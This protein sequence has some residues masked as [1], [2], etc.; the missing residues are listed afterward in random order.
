MNE[1]RNTWNAGKITTLALFSIAVFAQNTFGYAN[2]GKYCTEDNATCFD[3][4]ANDKFSL[5]MSKNKSGINTDATMSGSYTVN[6]DEFY[7]TIEQWDEKAELEA[8]KKTRTQKATET[9]DVAVK[10]LDLA[11]KANCGQQDPKK[12]AKCQKEVKEGEADIKRMKI[13]RD[14]IKNMTMTVQEKKELMDKFKER[15]GTPGY[16]FKNSIHLESNILTKS[17]LKPDFPKQYYCSNGELKEKGKFTDSRNGK[18]YTYVTIGSQ[19]WMAENLNWHGKDGYL[20]LC[21]GKKPE[22]CEIDG[23]LYDW[24]EAVGIDRKY[25]QTFWKNQEFWKKSMN[26]QGICPEGWYLPGDK[27][28][29]TLINFT[30]GKENAEKKLSVKRGQDES[31]CKYKTEDDRGRVTEHNNCFTDEYGFSGSS[32]WWSTAEYYPT[33]TYGNLANAVSKDYRY[34]YAEKSYARYVRCIKETAEAKAVVETARVAEATALAKRKD[35]EEKFAKTQFKDP[36]GKKYKIAITGGQ[37]WMAENLKYK[38]KGSKCYNNAPDENCGDDVLGRFY[39]WNTARSVC[40]NGWRLPTDA[41]WANAIN[42]ELYPKQFDG[43]DDGNGWIVEGINSARW[44]TSKGDGKSSVALLIDGG[45][46]SFVKIDNKLANSV[47]CVMSES[48]PKEEPTANSESGEKK[49]QKEK[50]KKIN[51]SPFKK[52]K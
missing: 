13:E 21:E 24:A 7:F 9:I 43:Y 6:C 37:I 50:T 35:L 47:R 34:D 8:I 28:W 3:L 18:V 16:I 52:K 2:E 23:R 31:K 48:S 27:E 12:I 22:N 10:V 15:L 44:W 40:P 38:A 20:G 42:D 5:F 17:G 14:N 49:Q 46:G 19:I 39:D 1:Q 36:A 41:E 29:Q 32:N 26:F 11:K 33:D 4:K 51:F 25:N 45:R 30:G